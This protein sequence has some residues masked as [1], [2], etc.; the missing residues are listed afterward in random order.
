MRCSWPTEWIERLGVPHPRY[1][2]LDRGAPIRSSWSPARGAARFDSG[3]LAGPDGAASLATHRRCSSRSAGTTIFDHGA[4]LA[5]RLRESLAVA[6][7]PRP[8]PGEASNLVVVRRRQRRRASARQCARARRRRGARDPR[9][10]LDQSVAR[11]LELRGRP[12]AACSL[13]SE[14]SAR[15]DCRIC[16][17]YAAVMSGRETAPVVDH[18]DVCLRQQAARGLDSRNGNQG[19]VPCSRSH[20]RPP[21]VRAEVRP[22][23]PR[24]RSACARPR[25]PA[26]SSRSSPARDR[27]AGRRS[28]ADCR[29]RSSRAGLR[30]SRS[31]SCPSPPRR[32][33]RMRPAPRCPAP[34][35]GRPGCRPE[36]APPAARSGRS[37]ATR[38]A[39]LMPSPIG[40]SSAGP[41][42]SSISAIRSC[43]GLQVVRALPR[44]RAD[45]A[46]V[47]GDDAMVAGELADQRR[48]T[49]RAPP[50]NCSAITISGPSPRSSQ[51]SV[52]P[53]GRW[54][55]GMRQ[56]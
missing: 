46:H 33:N 22:R 40:I 38:T 2:T 36:S 15:C 6:L 17:A 14:A 47:V 45:A 3:E 31:P 53:S 24:P 18:V 55:S 4:A 34:P 9:T 1:M 5:A 44:R 39:R 25:P 43:V 28:S 29:S 16:R 7:V 37:A 52:A 51:W 42:S 19:L 23:R 20:R 10:N 50:K 26:G 54:S 32:R 49:R 30:G 48:E 56:H 12:R 11:R 41:P 13:L 35:R 21:N 8:I 27:A